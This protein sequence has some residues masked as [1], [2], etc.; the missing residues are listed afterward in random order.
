M[1]VYKNVKQFA[2]VFVNDESRSDKTKIVRLELLVC[3]KTY[4][5]RIKLISSRFDS[6]MVI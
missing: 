1:L 6:P 5:Y 3:K 4:I 2:N